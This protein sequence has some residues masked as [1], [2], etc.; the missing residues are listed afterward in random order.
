MVPGNT[1]VKML[2]GRHEKLEMAIQATK[3][4]QYMPRVYGGIY[5]NRELLNLLQENIYKRLNLTKNKK[6]T[7]SVHKV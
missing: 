4:V 5:S 7:S 1:R 3:R 6:W 2:H